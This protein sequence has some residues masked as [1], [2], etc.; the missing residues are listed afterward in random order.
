MCRAMKAQTQRPPLGKGNLMESRMR[1]NV[2]VRCAPCGV[3]QYLS[4]SEKELKE[5]SWVDQLTRCRKADG[6]VACWIR[7]CLKAL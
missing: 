5:C 1:G 3:L 4:L 6:T 2:Q 7:T